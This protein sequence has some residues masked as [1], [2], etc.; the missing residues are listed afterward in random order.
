MDLMR[1]LRKLAMHIIHMLSIMDHWLA[2][3]TRSKLHINFTKY[4]LN[5][6]IKALSY[7]KQTNNSRYL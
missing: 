3:S 4:T 6:Q 7:V 5:L 2:I 1:S